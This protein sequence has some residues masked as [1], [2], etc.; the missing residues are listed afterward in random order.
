MASA[1]DIANMALIECGAESLT[2]LSDTTERARAC[3][4]AWPFVRRTVLRSHTWNP[5]IKR[6]QLDEDATAPLWGF[7][8][9]YALPNDYLRMLEVDTTYQW[10]IE[11]LYL[12]TDAA[13]DDLGV[14]Y[15]YDETDP[16]KYDSTL[17]DTMVLFLAYRIMNRVSA[18]KGM[19]DRIERQFQQFMAQAKN[20]DGQEQ[21]PAELEDDTYITCRY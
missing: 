20:I 6:A 15:I 9:R 4:A 21:T 2:A 18:D 3:N 13:G 11:G 7:D 17:T 12:Y 8:T 14:R 1:V 19:R 5:P 10:R 16:T